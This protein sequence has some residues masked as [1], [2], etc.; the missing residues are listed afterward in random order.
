M[1]KEIEMMRI[2]RVP[3]LAKLV[4]EANEERYESLSDVANPQVQQ[5][6]LAAIGELIA[7][8]GGYGGGVLRPRPLVGPPPPPSWKEAGVVPQTDAPPC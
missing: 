8:S 3:P 5:R 6:L 4:V 1:R 2:L 7:F